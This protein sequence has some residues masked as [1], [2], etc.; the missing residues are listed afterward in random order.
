LS[1]ARKIDDRNILVVYAA[2][3]LV[4]I[5]Y[6]ASTGVLSI[7]L[8]GYGFGKG[9][10]GAL[11]AAFATGIVTTSLPAGWLVRTIGA[12]RTLLFALLGYAITTGTFPMFHSLVPCAISRFVDG[13]LS[14]CVWVACETVL[15]ERARHDAK[16]FVTSIYAMCFAGGYIAGPLLARPLVDGRPTGSAF[17]LASALALA[18]AL[19]V[20]L[21]LERTADGGQR[22]ADGGR[23]TGDGGPRTA[24][25]GPRTGDG[26]RRL[27]GADI[28]WRIKTS[29][30]AT[31]GYGYFQASVVLFLP[32]FL[33]EKRG[34]PEN[35]TILITAFFAAGMLL[36]TN[37]AGRIGDRLGHLYLMRVLAAIGT[38]MICGF[39]FLT[40]FWLMCGAVF[41]AGATLASISPVSLALLGVVTPKHDLARGNAIYNA[42]YASGMLLGPPVSS[43][44]FS[45]QGGEAMLYHLAA[46]WC[47]F[48]LFTVVFVR[49]DPAAARRAAERRA[50]VSG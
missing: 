23:R 21:Q 42:F 47:A 45:T 13:G 10:M 19:V 40:K 28:L 29:C 8:K 24:D 2:V 41:V 4:G 44:I 18:S 37:F 15:L 35:D 5:A 30:F 39:V 50:A 31:F 36:F 20:L 32:L 27:S 1:A 33:I 43:L 25:G 6:G 7:H 49:D 17:W 48:V 11:A 16:A 12:R 14:V 26:G 9:E 22:T 38:V 3:L 46:L 34:V